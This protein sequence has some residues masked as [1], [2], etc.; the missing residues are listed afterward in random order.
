MVFPREIFHFAATRHGS[1]SRIVHEVT[2]PIADL[3]R[4]AAFSPLE[5][6]EARKHRRVLF[7]AGRSR[8]VVRYAS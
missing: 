2:A 1:L 3:R 4:P 5:H 7:I 6:S 8:K